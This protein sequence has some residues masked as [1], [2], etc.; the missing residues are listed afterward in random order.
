MVRQVLIAEVLLL[1]RAG[2]YY[3][4]G[5][6]DRGTDARD[7]RGVEVEE[8]RRQAGGGLARGGAA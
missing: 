5:A 4:R 6:T 7:F 2:L 1:L 3:P 8:E